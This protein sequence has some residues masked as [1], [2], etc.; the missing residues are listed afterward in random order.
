MRLDVSMEEMFP[1]AVARVW[2]ALTDSQMI[3][4]C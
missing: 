3:S 4:R 1:V 2:H